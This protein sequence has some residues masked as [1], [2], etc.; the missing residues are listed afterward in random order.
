MLSSI[1]K[2][3]KRLKKARM[4][5]PHRHLLSP[6]TNTS[7][8]R[9]RWGL[10]NFLQ[11]RLEK[12]GKEYEKL[13]ANTIKASDPESK[14]VLFHKKSAVLSE[15]TNL[16]ADLLYKEV[17][18]SFLRTTQERKRS[19]PRSRRYIMEK[20]EEIARVKAQPPT[21][22]YSRLFASETWSLKD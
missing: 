17:R 20:W 4:D 5:I 15:W 14:A 8:E 22:R 18:G 16:A 7:P 6:S 11:T 3:Q 2:K 13:L 19:M 1:T 10:K 9:D 21:P 12:L